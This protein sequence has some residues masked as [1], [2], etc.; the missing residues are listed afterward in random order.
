MGFT[1]GILAEGG[2]PNSTN[3]WNLTLHNSKKQM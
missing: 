2:V 1:S 3:Y